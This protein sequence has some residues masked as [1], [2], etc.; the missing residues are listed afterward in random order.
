MSSSPHNWS[1]K[2]PAE[3]DLEDI[4][5]QERKDESSWKVK[6]LDEI[7]QEKRKRLED[8]T[9]G[10]E[11]KEVTDEREESQPASRN[12]SAT[13]SPGSL[14]REKIAPNQLESPA[15]EVIYHLSPGQHSCSS[16]KYYI[17]Q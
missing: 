5:D 15:A 12:S 6:T 11:E 17:I 3:D 2:R 7:L 16:C 14:K 9:G 10:K 13:A 4:S 1:R 8:E